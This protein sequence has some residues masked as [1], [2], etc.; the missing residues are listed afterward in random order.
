MSFYISRVRITDEI[1]CLINRDLNW[2]NVAVFVYGKGITDLMSLFPSHRCY[3]EFRNSVILTSDH[4]TKG[5]RL[6]LNK[7][8]EIVII[9][10]YKKVLAKLGYFCREINNP[11]N[12]CY[13]YK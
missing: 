11:T 12:F 4:N 1:S 3:L 6:S 2:W 9:D 10:Q 13:L 5:T 8:G 7:D